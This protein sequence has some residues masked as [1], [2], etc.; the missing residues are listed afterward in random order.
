MK[1]R[2]ANP[3]IPAMMREKI[4]TIKAD[5]HRGPK[6]RRPTPVAVLAS[7]PPTLASE[8]PPP[9]EEGGGVLA[10]ASSGVTSLLRHTAN[11]S[12]AVGWLS[13]RRRLKAYRQADPEFE[14]AS[15]RGKKTLEPIGGERWSTLWRNRTQTRPKIKEVTHT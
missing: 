11:Q 8:L 14:Q 7:S 6:E 12:V 10:P 2:D 15:A 5:N 1:H 9:S 13:K 4:A 3:H